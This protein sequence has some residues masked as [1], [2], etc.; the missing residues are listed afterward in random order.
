M[1][2]RPR[3]CGHRA[4][5]DLLVLRS[6][7]L[8]FTS[9]LTFVRTGFS[10]VSKGSVTL[11][12]SVKTLLWRSPCLRSPDGIASY[13]YGLHEALTTCEANSNKLLNSLQH[14]VSMLLYHT[15]QSSCS[16]HSHC[17]SHTI[18][19]SLCAHAMHIIKMGFLNLTFR[20]CVVFVPRA[21]FTLTLRSGSSPSPTRQWA[22]H[23]LHA[24]RFSWNI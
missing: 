4:Q 16:I 14:C 2:R 8:S 18:L 20:A 9:G 6:H 1:Q 22:G 5:T 17:V 11:S 13:A 12:S 10:R 3:M 7:Q 15:S 23:I 21:S 19:P 24:R